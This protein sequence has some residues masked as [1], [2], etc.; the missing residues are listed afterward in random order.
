MGVSRLGSVTVAL[1]AMGNRQVQSNPTCNASAADGL[2]SVRH[3]SPLKRLLALCA[4][5]L[6]SSCASGRGSNDSAPQ[7]KRA[8]EPSSEAISADGI[9]VCPL[10]G[11]SPDPWI[12]VTAMNNKLRHYPEF[13]R[14]S[15]LTEV[16][17]CADGW[18]F[19]KQYDKYRETYP[20]F[21]VNEPY[22]PPPFVDREE[23][24]PTE[25]ELRAA[26]GEGPKIKN[27]TGAKLSPVVRFYFD[28]ND[29]KGP[30][31]HYCTGTF[32]GRNW[33]LTAAHCLQTKKGW[34]KGDDPDGAAPNGY[35]TINVQYYGANGKLLPTGEFNNTRQYAYTQ[36]IMDPWYTGLRPGNPYHAHDAA[37]LYISK[38]FDGMLP[39]M[40]PA[41]GTNSFPL[42]RV[43]ATD[44]LVDVANATFWGAGLLDDATSNVAGSGGSGGSSGS[45]SSGSGGR[46]GT[47][48]SGSGGIAGTDRLIYREASETEARLRYGSLAPYQASFGLEPEPAQPPTAFDG[49][50][51][52]ANVDRTLYGRLF[53]SDYPSTPAS[54]TCLGDSGGPLVE[55][56][57]IKDLGG[58]QL[59]GYVTAGILSQHV[60]KNQAP[61]MSDSDCAGKSPLPH[62]D[63]A[64]H[65]CFDETWSC[66]DAPGRGSGWV[67]NY[68]EVEFIRDSI[69]KWYK[70]KFRCTVSQRIETGTGSTTSDQFL[71][72]WGKACKRTACINND[73]STDPDC[74][75][76]NENCIR[77]GSELTSCIPCPGKTDSSPDKCACYYGQ[78]FPRSATK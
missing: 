59:T 64:V 41:L 3:R 57:L 28:K 77:P 46:G 51:G 21:D 13:A 11:T 30:L 17:S 54:Y 70:S 29:N 5:A 68:H 35:Y 55:L 45:G 7:N 44:H 15:G 6:L 66:V 38:N 63:M 75:A 43:S 74:C 31:Y 71:Q 20:Y 14:A 37:L 22:E 32:I 72:C 52:D 18:A 67:A 2:A 33:I 23:P 24:T 9:L 73:P 78:C 40:D 50:L 65:E 69:Q 58:T 48:G 60:F 62:C 36:Q 8:P 4:I 16:K 12:S 25:A 61:C 1:L 26:Q 10:E 27:G 56:W 76:A 47:S 42:M 39:N 49:S 34:H 53:Y 19:W